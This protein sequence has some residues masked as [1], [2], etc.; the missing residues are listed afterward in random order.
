MQKGKL[1]LIP[2]SLG[3]D[4][5]ASV[6]PAQ[7]FKLINE[8]DH[9]IVENI[10][11]AAKFLKLAG[12]KK[13]LKE[14]TFYLLTKDTNPDEYSSYLDE[15]INGH[16]IGLLSEAGAPCIADPGAVIAALAHEKKIRVIPLS[17][18]SS[19]IMALM[20]SGLNG[21]NFAFIGYLPIDQKARREKLKEL[22]RKIRLENQ[23]QIFI[24]AP[25]RNDKLF[26]EILETC[27]S[28]LKLSVSK[29]LTMVDEFI[30][31]ETISIWK[32]HRTE[33]G[34]NPVI[35]ILGK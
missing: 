7:V 29:N 1:Y 18:P 11:S 31:T 16:N 34:K 28:E 13:P 3:S 35:F 4:D 33:F 8:I 25:H 22:E 23:S 24:E 21:Q 17:G 9:Y 30:R 14:L 19:I 12:L 2:T 6:I 15:A 20:A 27:S 10:K 5:L 26:N 32:K